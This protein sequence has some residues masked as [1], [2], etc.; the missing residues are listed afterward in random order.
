[1]LDPPWELIS[2]SATP[3]ESTRCRMT[4]IAWA[5]VSEVTRDSSWAT[6]ARMSCVPPSRSRASLGVQVASDSLVPAKIA[7]NTATVITASV[8]R[9]RAGWR[10]RVGGANGPSSLVRAPP[11][12]GGRCG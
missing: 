7:P 6:G 2:A 1:M 9:M 3:D 12:D 10:R 5:M 8:S 11:A 4:S